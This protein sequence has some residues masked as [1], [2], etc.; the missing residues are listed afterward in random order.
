MRSPGPR[1]SSLVAI[2]L[3]ATAGCKS[4]PQASARS[5]QAGT[6]PPDAAASAAVEPSLL[7]RTSNDAT[8]ERY[9]RVDSLVAQWDAS[10]A[11]GRDAEAAGLAT[12]VGE[13]VDADFALFA[14]AARGDQGL[15]AQSLAVKA[16]AFSTRPEATDLLVTRLGDS[17]PDLVANALIG[18][19]LRA[20]PATPLPPLLR[21]LRSPSTSHRRFAP[22]ALANVLLARERAGLALEPDFAGQ[23][24]TGLVGLVQD[25]DPLV[26]LH[27][28]KAMGALRRPEATDFLVLLLKDDHPRIR[29]AAAAALERVG[30]PRAF[31][32]VVELLDRS[33]D[34]TKP[35]VR[36]VLVSYAARL[37]GS[38]LAPVEVESLGTSPREWDR[39]FAARS[40]GRVPSG[41]P[42]APAPAT[43]LPPPRP[44]APSR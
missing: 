22:L 3:L 16:L 5:P 27:A 2:A 30:D 12:K 1:G 24:A 13:E 8:S 19:K 25:R 38:P 36:D 35:L 32:K 7:P 31:P 6:P 4:S 15:R 26:R 20:D 43:T 23:A 21:L 41:P 39:W 29:V 18:L 17:D 33:D 14:S 37:Q 28:A 34:A 44:V 10:Q 11:D 40:T 42:P 9:F